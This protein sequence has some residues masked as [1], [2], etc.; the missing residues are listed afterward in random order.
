MSCIKFYVLL[1]C[2]SVEQGFASRD[3][4]HAYNFKVSSEEGVTKCTYKY[5]ASE[6][7]IYW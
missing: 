4:T 3:C 6:E 5:T 7:S 2:N 1:A